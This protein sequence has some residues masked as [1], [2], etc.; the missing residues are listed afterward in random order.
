MAISSC[1]LELNSPSDILSC[2]LTTSG[3]L[4]YELGFFTIMIIVVGGWSLTLGIEKGMAVGGFL[5]S[6]IGVIG[7]VFGYINI[8]SVMFAVFVMIIGALL[9]IL[10][11]AKGG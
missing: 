5:M 2:F 9:I 3:G 6:L 10:G 4:I 1:L 11:D 8:V 7:L